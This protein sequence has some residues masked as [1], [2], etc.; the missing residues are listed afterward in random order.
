M[1]KA[2]FKACNI[3]V[4]CCESMIEEEYCLDD[5]CCTAT[6]VSVGNPHCVI[7]LQH[8]PKDFRMKTYGAMSE[9]NPLFPQGVNTEFIFVEG[10]NLIDMR[11]W[12]RDSSE[13]YSC[14][15]GACAVTKAAVENDWCEVGKPIKV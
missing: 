12:E 14:D 1:D 8:K 9:H 10:K 3:P 13:T 5:F 2:S 6:T 11:V 4:A 7:Q 15:T